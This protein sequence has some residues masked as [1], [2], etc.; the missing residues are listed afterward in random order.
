MHEFPWFPF[1][2]TD[3][4]NSRKVRTMSPEEVGIY[5]LLL[6]H[7]WDGGPLPD[8][9]VELSSLANGAQ[10]NTVRTVLERCFVLFEHGWVNERLE[11]VRV[12]QVEKREQKVRA[13]IASGKSRGSKKLPSS[14]TVRTALESRSN[15]KGTDPEQTESESDKKETDMS[16]GVISELAS[17]LWLTWIEELG[18]RP[19]HPRLTAK[20]RQK[21]AALASE[22]LVESTDPVAD[23]RALLRAVKASEHHMSK[24]EYQMPESLFVSEERRDT[25]MQKARANGTAKHWAD[26]L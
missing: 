13:G 6:C 23:F 10:S 21:L 26:S 25:W 16:N 1:Y 17:K 15:R 22:H 12:E 2:A 3:F 11:Q 4:T 9:D 20:R 14:N 5:T 19:P 24:R 8:D 18:G 7:Q